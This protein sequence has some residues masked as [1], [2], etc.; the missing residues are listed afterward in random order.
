[1]K[2]APDFDVAELIC[3]C[4]CGTFIYSKPA[5][6]ALQA[7]RT[8]LGVPL[9]IVSGTR[10]AAHNKAVGGAPKSFH[11]TGQAFD[12]SHATVD[13]TTLH[14]YALL[15]GFNV[16]RTY[17]SFTHCDIGPDRIW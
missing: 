11:L 12:V 9:H 2:I 4:G 7:L 3:H 15:C 1:M 16:A 10:C 8:A 17:P 5:L 14:Q 13:A 6:L